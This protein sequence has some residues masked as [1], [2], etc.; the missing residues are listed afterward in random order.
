MENPDYKALYE[1]SQIELELA[2]KE[3]EQK[4]TWCQVLEQQLEGQAR[5]IL[6]ISLKMDG[7]RERTKQFIK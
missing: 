3:L 6:E 4:N 2:R 1:T 7:L 5:D